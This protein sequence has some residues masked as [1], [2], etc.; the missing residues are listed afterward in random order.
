MPLTLFKKHKI[1]ELEKRIPREEL[2]QRSRILVIDDEEPEL[3]ADIRQSG[4]AVD[5]QPDITNINLSEIDKPKY[6]LI[7]L[8]FGDVGS[9]F[10]S[11]QGLSLLKHI[12]RVNPTAHVIAY[13]SKSLGSEHAE[14][15]RLAD[16]VLRK[17]AGIAES[18]EKIEE[19]LSEARSIQNT[20]KGLLRA[21]GVEPG[22]KEDEAWQDLFV[23]GLSKPKKMHNLKDQIARTVSSEFGQGLALMLVEKL[24]E[25]GG[26]AVGGGG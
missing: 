6:D 17:D 14:F 3:L 25:L 26:R 20:W 2:L 22:S 7:I 16:G 5:Y 11:D 23:K 21:A 13:T 9:A 15:Y 10:G 12:K 1:E 24:T 4:F 19:A 18:M 8:D